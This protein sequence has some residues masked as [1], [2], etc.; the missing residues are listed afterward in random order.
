MQCSFLKPTEKGK[1]ED[2]SGRKENKERA[3]VSCKDSKLENIEI[4]H[5]TMLS[6]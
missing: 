5:K 4:W 1:L 3:K 2:L 6:G